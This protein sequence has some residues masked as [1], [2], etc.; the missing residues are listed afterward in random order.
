MQIFE[1]IISLQKTLKTFQ[2][3]NKSIGFVPTMGALHT[4]HLSLIEQSKEENDYTVVSIYV[5]PAQFNNA[6]D[7]EKYPRT[8][9]D[10]SRQLESVGC[11]F[12]FF[13]SNEIMYPNKASLSFNFGDLEHSME[14]AF[15]EG[16]FNGVALVVSKLFNIVKPNRAYFG[17]KDLQQYLIIKTLK[18][19]L[20][21]DLEVIACPIKR[22]EDGLA[23]S[24]RNMRLNPVQRKQAIAL[25]QALSLAK[26]MLQK[27]K[28]SIE[29]TQKEISS[30]IA[31]FSL[32]KLEYFE[33]VNSQNLKPI[34][35]INTEKEV[36]LCIAAYLGNI[37]LIDNMI[38][39]L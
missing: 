29:H 23:M 5:N 14:G 24:S 25:Y 13:P 7:L 11:D 10:D 38:F 16:H 20:F 36:A 8:L 1:N 12:L 6:S 3:Q 28:L 22:E 30:L 18:E 27:E 19:N 31:E 32:V 37:R 33:I 4:G 21:F 17:Q 26:K 39:Q 9:E 35:N 2:N 15:R 34:K